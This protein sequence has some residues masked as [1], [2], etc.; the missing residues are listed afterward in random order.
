MGAMKAGAAAA[1][2]E[3]SGGEVVPM[4][5]TIKQNSF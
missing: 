5:K 2:G 3:T 1:K 4:T